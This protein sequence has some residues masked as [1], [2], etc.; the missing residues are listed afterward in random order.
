MTKRP[1]KGEKVIPWKLRIFYVLVL[2]LAFFG[3]AGGVEGWLIPTDADGFDEFLLWLLV[4]AF[5]LVLEL[6]TVVLL[7]RAQ[8]LRHAGEP[9]GWMIF[10]ATVLAFGAAAL[11]FVGHWGP[12]QEDKIQACAFAGITLLGF[13]IWL[14]MSDLKEQPFITRRR[15]VKAAVEQFIKDLDLDAKY[16]KLVMASVDFDNIADAVTRGMENDLIADM[17]GRAIAP[18][19]WNVE[20]DE[21]A[22]QA[23]A[24]A[25]AAIRAEFEGIVSRLQGQMG[26]ALGQAAALE[27]E[28]AQVRTAAEAEKAAL[29]QE[30]EDRLRETSQVPARS[31]AP[32]EEYA[33][34]RGVV[35][36]GNGSAPLPAP[37]PQAPVAPQPVPRQAEPVSAPT[38]RAATVG[39]TVLQPQAVPQQARAAQGQQVSGKQALLGAL[40][41]LLAD[42]KVALDWTPKALVRAAEEV[43]VHLDNPDS[44]AR[45]ARDWRNAPR[46]ELEP[47]PARVP[48]VRYIADRR[49]PSEQ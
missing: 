17:L 24:E 48:G 34:T 25:E 21:D 46:P 41:Q 35:Q 15:T 42:E 29:E 4:V 44:A 22:A 27:K 8:E 45:Y 30:L 9:A 3:Q 33:G 14:F 31:E 16:K 28:L 20:D 7:S 5:V 11:S 12:K 6:G 38:A 39:N 19:A 40:E 13:L 18:A 23:R 1:A 43:G 36:R 2:V 37:A 49:R 32:V 10:A 26:E 47:E